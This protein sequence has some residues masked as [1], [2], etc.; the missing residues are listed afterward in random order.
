MSDA[1]R[2]VRF[3]MIDTSL[4]TA[5]RIDVLVAEL[6]DDPRCRHVLSLPAVA[7]THAPTPTAL[8]AELGTYVPEAGL[9]SH[10]AAALD[11]ALAG[12]SL[13]LT[14]A[15]SS[16]KSLVYQLAIA[17][18]AVSDPGAATALAIFPTKALAYDQLRSMTTFEP[19][20]VIPAT[21]DG[22]LGRDERA[23][24]R[25][26]ANVILTNPDMLHYALLSNHRRWAT[27]LKRLR[28]VVVDEM[29]LFRG[30][31][32][33]HVAHVLRR[34]RRLCAAYGSDPVFI[35]CSAT[36]GEPARLA[37]DLSGLEVTDVSDD[38][39]PR[40]TK[41]VV[42]WNPRDLDPDGS[43]NVVGSHHADVV[44]LATR[45]VDA[46]LTSLV[47]CRS[48]RSVEI[49]AARLA[50]AVSPER[51]DRIRPYRGGYLAAERRQIE[52]DLAEGR[53]DAVVATSALEV[54][55]DIGAAD[56]AILSGVPSTI[57]SMWQQIGRVGRRDEPSLAVVVGGD[58]QLDQWVMRHPSD[59]LSRPPERAVVNPANPQILDAHLA[60]AA[61]ERRLDRGD[62]EFW[63]DDLDDA[64][65]RGVRN[66]SLAVRTVG[67]DVAAVFDGEGRPAHRIGLRSAGGGE[68]SIRT[69]GGELIGTIEAARAPSTVH[70][71][72]VY[73]HHGRSWR[74]T[75]L[76]LD[77]LRAT[78]VPDPG[79]TTTQTTSRS[80]VRLLDIDDQRT[81][82]SLSAFVGPVEVTEQVTGYRE[83][84]ISNR[85]V[86]DKRRLEMPEHVLPT[87]AFWY[88]FEP[89]LLGRAGVD[90]LS[91]P[92]TLHAVEHAG[93][94]I[95]PLFAICDRSDVGGLST[96]THPDTGAP[97]IIIHEAA[98]GGVGISELGFTAG[99][100]HLAATLSVIERCP[101]SAGCPSCIQSPK[102]GN[103]N[104]PLDKAGAVS[105][106][107]LI[108]A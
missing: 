73:L 52:A 96:A 34:L 86:V 12:Q 51:A 101:C 64:I 87:R 48:R 83:M 3:E 58:D 6:T 76:D 46:D 90:A 28:Y 44:N 16:G 50:E 18:A 103:L 13:C 57:S 67:G 72:A 61:F 100:R 22:D 81:G 38:G 14:S 30:V 37:S 49:T 65:M 29:H 82:T 53:L 10:Q 36:I 39:A 105:L 62:E 85:E 106:L 9:W 102:C 7:A 5:Q 31:F 68:V 98:S 74:V 26:H 43:W 63:G 79:E 66:G 27:F 45:C 15:T 75:E 108:L 99:E 92:G 107:R 91:A 84:V 47:F 41:T 8:S 94:G 56:T 70:E 19:V 60:A 88:V 20:G 17:D 23:W 2:S 21:F 97:T 95:L 35:F 80:Q 42:L 69:A 78:V 54:G 25:S 104:E 11:Q 1:R 89:E 32:G 71:G 55:V 93:I 59:T 33:S 4:T 77:D 24:V 40:A